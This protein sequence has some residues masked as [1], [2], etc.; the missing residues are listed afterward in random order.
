MNRHGGRTR[1]A[2]AAS[3][4]LAL[5]AGGLASIA[6]ASTKPKDCGRL[7]AGIGGPLPSGVPAGSV[8]EV[9]AFRVG[10]SLGCKTVHSVMQKFENN[11]SSTLTINKTPAPGWT[12]KFN[13]KARGY[14]CR[15]GKDV[16]EDQVIYKLH[17]SP[18]GPRPRTP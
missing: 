8:P 6:A 9:H 7:A 1:G 4:A 12:C 17:G 11:A 5:G 13:R 3:V 15:K 18:V 14:V 16:I 10:G 2:V